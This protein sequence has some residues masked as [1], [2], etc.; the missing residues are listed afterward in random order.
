[1][2][3]ISQE[4][5]LRAVELLRHQIANIVAGIRRSLPLKR[6]GLFIAVGGDVRLAAQQIG[7]PGEGRSR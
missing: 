1:M 6:M 3:S 7:I 2:L 5:P 4:P